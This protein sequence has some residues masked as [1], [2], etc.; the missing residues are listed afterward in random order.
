MLLRNKITNQIG[1]FANHQ[2]IDWEQL[3]E[4]EILAYELQEA[5]TAKLAQILPARNAFM[6]AD[7]EYK[8]SYFT[9]SQVSGN[10]LTAEIADQ[11]PIIEWLYANGNRV[12]LTLEEAKELSSLIKAKRRIGYFQEASLINQI[13]NISN[14]TQYF[15]EDGEEI[16]ALQ[17]L[18][19][20]NIN[21]E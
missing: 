7:I 2:G 18:D 9:N 19:N 15:N 8:G 11:T 4:N 5:K 17:A 3:T 6:Y 12:D 21:F 1:T 13:N 10:N 16:S 14:D 20:I